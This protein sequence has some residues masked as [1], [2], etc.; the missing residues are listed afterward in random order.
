MPIKKTKET[1]VPA[2][3][4]AATGMDYYLH[5]QKVKA[6]EAEIKKLRKPLENHVNEKGNVTDSGTKIA[7]LPFADKQVILKNVYRCSSGL[8]A[9][10]VNIAKEVPVLA[11][12]IETVEFFR[13]D[14]LAYKIEEGLVS[15]ELLKKLYET[16]ESYAFSVDVKAKLDEKDLDI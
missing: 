12:C 11:D 2:I 14:V 3:D 9:E 1:N 7:I 8:V 4:I 16:K 5:K 15:E 13:E 6:L 10:A